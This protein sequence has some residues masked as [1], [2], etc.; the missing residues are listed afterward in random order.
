MVSR[1][2]AWIE[3]ITAGIAIAALAV[4][5]GS[6]FVA[7]KAVRVTQTQAWDY[8]GAQQCTSYRTEVIRLHELGMG[9]EEI[10]EWFR[11]EKGGQENPFSNE[12]HPT[13][14]DAFADGCG[15]VDELLDL[16]PSREE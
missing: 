13:A 10:K 2:D 6:L 8:L 4:S 9:R 11:K 16:M 14:Y 12:G 1:V 7:R 3:I 5:L 15:T